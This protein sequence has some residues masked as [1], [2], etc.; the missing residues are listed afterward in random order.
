MGKEKATAMVVAPE[1]ECRVILEFMT[2]F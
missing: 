1:M 2:D